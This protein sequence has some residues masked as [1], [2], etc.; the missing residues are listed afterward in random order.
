MSDP[1]VRIKD[2]L[3]QAVG[4]NLPAYGMSSRSV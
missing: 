3:G 2:R 4:D 1:L